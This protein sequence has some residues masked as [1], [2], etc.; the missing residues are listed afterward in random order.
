M[1]AVCICYNKIILF[2]YQQVTKLLSTIHTQ[3]LATNNKTYT[4]H[5]VKRKLEKYLLQDF[6]LYWKTFPFSLV[7]MVKYGVALSFP[8]VGS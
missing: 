7:L 2:H 3:I 8:I 6:I 1:S 5:C 4:C